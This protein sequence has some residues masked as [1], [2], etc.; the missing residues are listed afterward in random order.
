MKTA[1]LNTHATAATSRN[2]NTTATPTTATNCP[3][4]KGTSGASG[5]KHSPFRGLG[6]FF[7]T[8]LLL[9]FATTNAWAQ[10]LTD[11]MFAKGFGGYTTNGF[12]AAG[13]DRSGKA[14]ST[15]KTDVE[16]S[17]QVFNGSTGAVR[18]NQSTLKNNFSCRNT[19]TKEGYYI[20]QVSL[21]VS[22]G[23]ID[24]S[25]SGR[26]VVYFGETAFT[27]SPSGTP[28]NASPAS[29]GQTTL[30]WTN[31]DTD[32]SYFILFGL[33][34]SGTA[35]SANE[36]TSLKVVWSPAG[37]SGTEN[38]LAF[39]NG[40]CTV[41]NMIELST[42]KKTGDNNVTP[43]TYAFEG[44]V[45]NSDAE[46]S[47]GIFYGYKLGTYTINATQAEGNGYCAGTAQFTVTVNAPEYTYTWM[48]NGMQHD[49]T[50]GSTVVLPSTNP[51]VPIGCEG[52]MFVGWT[53]EFS[54]SNA[55]TAPTFVKAGDN[56]GS[57]KTFYAVFA[58]E[59][60]EGGSGTAQYEKVTSDQ[61][62]WEGQYLIAYS[63]A[64][65][66]DGSLSGT[67]PGALNKKVAPESNLTGNN[68]TATWGDTY[69]FTLEAVTGGYVL[70]SKAG[71]YLYQTTNA[72]G[73]KATDNQSTAASYP[74]TV[75][76]TSASDIKLK[77]GGA[78][79]G[80]VL[81]Y[82]TSGYFRYYKNGGQSAIYLY[83]KSGGS[84][85]TYSD[86]TTQCTQPCTSN[87]L[88]FRN[89][90]CFV[91][92]EF[93]LSSL[94]SGNST[95]DIIY[96][97]DDEDNVI[98]VDNI[99]SAITAGVY[100]VTAYQ[101]E[102]N[103]ICE[104]SEI[105]FTVTVKPVAD[106][107][108][109]WTFDWQ[110]TPG[111]TEWSRL[112]FDGPYSP[113]A[114]TGEYTIAN[115]T[116]P[117]G[118]CQFTVGYEGVYDKAHWGGWCYKVNFNSHMP[119]ANYRGWEIKPI[120]G[121][122]AVGTL[123]I[124][125]NS[126]SDNK[127]IGFIPSGYSVT[128]GIEGQGNEAT[129]VNVPFSKKEGEN[130]IWETAEVIISSSFS[131][132]TKY[133]TGITKADPNALSAFCNNKSNTTLM[134]PLSTQIG[135]GVHGIF[136]MHDTY[137]NADGDNF[138][139]TFM[140]YYNIV[141][142]KSDNT[143]IDHVS[144][145]KSC[146]L[147]RDNGE[148]DVT[149]DAPTEVREGYTFKGWSHEQ[150]GEV[151][152]GV[153]GTYTLDHPNDPLY[154]VWSKNEYTITW[155]NNGTTFATTTVDW[156]K[157]ITTLPD[158]PESCDATYSNFV[159]W[160][161]EA[162]GTQSA[163]NTSAP[164]TQV[165]TNT[166]PESNVTYHAVF[167][168]AEGSGAE[169]WSLTELSNITASD[170][171]VIAWKNES[172]TY[173]VMSNDKGTSSAPSAT[174]V[175]V[176]SN[177]ITSTIAATQKWN[178]SNSSG[179]LTIYPQGTT[180]TWLYC[181]STNNG[182]RVGN[183][184]N[185]IF[186]IDGESGYLKNT[187]TSRY[188]GVYNNAD[189]RC[190]I[191]STATNIQNQTLAFFKKSIDG[192][193]ATGY[194]SSCC[195]DPA[196]VT[197]TPASASVNL[198]ENGDASVNVTVS[199]EGVTVDNS[200]LSYSVS[201]ETEGVSFNGSTFS[202]TGGVAKVGT[203]TIS[204]AYTDNC[205][206]VGSATIEVKATPVVT[207]V[208]ADPISL[209]AECGEKET[210][211]ITVS[212]YN[213]GS[214]KVKLAFEPTTMFVTI[215]E[216][217][218]SLTPDADGKV[219]KEITITYTASTNTANAGTVEYSG[220]LKASCG[221][222]EPASVTITATKSSTCNTTRVQ[223]MYKDAELGASYDGYYGEAIDATAV[224]T[225]GEQAQAAVC[226]TPT[227]Y[228]FVGWS[229]T[230]NEVTPVTPTDKTVSG[231]SKYYAY[232][233]YVENGET[234]TTAKPVCGAYVQITNN[235][236]VYVTGGIGT[237]YNTVQ[238]QAT[239]DFVAD[240]LV[241]KTGATEDP[242]VRVLP[243]DITV[244]GTQTTEIKVEQLEQTV[245][246][247]TDGTFKSVGKFIVKYTPTTAEQSVD[248]N[249][250][251]SVRNV[252]LAS[253][254]AFTVHARSLPEQFVIVGQNNGTWYA[255]P[256]NMD[257]AAT[258]A[259]NTQLVLDNNNP[260]VAEIAPNAAVYKFDAMPSTEFR[261][262]RF[263]GNDNSQYLWATQASDGEGTNIRNWATNTPAYSETYYNWLLTTTDN[264]TYT[265]HNQGNNRN[266]SL[267]GEKFGMF[268]SG[269]DQLRIL[270]ITE[271]CNYAPAPA[272]LAVTNLGETTATAT[273][274][275]ISGVSRYEYK[276]NDGGWTTV[277]TNSATLGLVKGNAYTLTVRAKLDGSNTCVD[278]A[279]TT[280]AAKNYDLTIGNCP[281]II[282][283][284]GETKQATVT[285][286]VVDVTTL[287]AGTITGDH[288]NMF[289]V[290]AGVSG[291]TVT[292]APPAGTPEG[293]YTATVV[294]TGTPG[295]RTQTLTLR[296]RVQNTIAMQI[297]CDWDDFCMDDGVTD[298][299]MTPYT[300]NDDT[301][302]WSN[303]NFKKG[304]DYWSDATGMVR[305]TDMTTGEDL[306][307][308][309]IT[310]TAYNIR[311]PKSAL[312]L[313]HSYRFEIDNSDGS[314][315]NA[316][317]TPYA[318]AVYE[319]TA[320]YCYSVTA[321]TPCAISE[322]GFT[323]RWDCGLDNTPA[324][325]TLEVYTKVPGAT[326]WSIDY[327]A[328]PTL[329]IWTYAG[330][331][332]MQEEGG[333][334]SNLSNSAQISYTTDG[335]QI[336]KAS[337]FGELYSPTFANMQNLPTDLAN[338]EVT[339]SITHV[340]NNKNNYSFR[341]YAVE[342]TSAKAD[343]PYAK[344][345]MYDVYFNGS[346]TKTSYLTISGTPTDQ[347]TTFTVKGLTST[348]HILIYGDESTAAGP[349]IK[350]VTI[351]TAT[352]KSVLTTGYNSSVACANGDAG[353]A[354]TGL[355][356][357][358]TYYY[359][360]DGTNEIAV[361]TRSAAPE[362]NFELSK[363]TLQS[364][365]ACVLGKM[366]VSGTNLTACQGDFSWVLTGEDKSKFSG[367][368]TNL[369]Y[370]AT[371][372][373]LSGYVVVEY[374]PTESGTDNATLT[375]TVGDVS[376]DIVLEGLSCLDMAE[377]TVT[378]GAIYATL[379]LQEETSG[380]VAVT[381]MG[382]KN[383]LITNPGFES[384]KSGWGTYIT[385]YQ[386]DSERSTAQ[387]HSG[388]AS[389]YASHG[390]D[391]Y[392]Q[393]NG[394]RYHLLAPDFRMTAGNTY[395]F[396]AWVYPTD[397]EDFAIGYYDDEASTNVRDYKLV[398]LKKNTWT[399]VSIT[400][401]V[402]AAASNS[403]L[404]PFIARRNHSSWNGFYVDDVVLAQTGGSATES[405]IVNN[406]TTVTLDDLTPGH[407]YQYYLTNTNTGCKYGP[408]EFATNDSVVQGAIIIDTPIELSVQ[409]SQSVSKMVVVD[410]KWLA[411]DV[412]IMK[413]N[414]QLGGGVNDPCSWFTIN[415]TTVDANG[416]MISVTFSPDI[417]AVPGTSFSCHCLAT[418]VDLQGTQVTT[419]FDLIGTVTAGIDPSLPLVEVVDIDETTLVIEHNVADVD[420]VQIVLNRELT[421][422]EIQENVGCELFFSKYYEASSTVKLWAVFNP[423]NDTISLKGTYVWLG[424]NGN[425]WNKRCDLS[426]M[427][428][429]K[430]GYIAPQEE[431]IVY[432]SDGR[433]AILNC[434]S[435][436]ADMTNWYG[437]KPAN[438]NALSFDGNDAL[439][440]VRSPE[441]NTDEKV[442]T[443][444]YSS[445][446]VP[447]MYIL[448]EGK[449]T[450]RDTILNWRWYDNYDQDPGVMYQILD[451]VG[452]RTAANV[453]DN[454]KC[455]TPKFEDGQ[456]GD[457]DGWVSTTGADMN[458]KREIVL[459]TN[460]CLLVRDKGVKAGSAAV[461]DNVGDFIT[462][463]SEWQGS[464]VPS[465]SNR[466]NEDSISC[467]NFTYVGAFDYAGYYATYTTLNADEY[468]FTLQ[469]RDS[470]YIAEN[471]ESLTEYTCKKLLIE[472]VAV[473]N[474]NGTE[475]KSLVTS[476]EYKVPII[477][478]SDIKTTDDKFTQFTVDTC[479]ECDVVIIDN[480]KLTREVNSD[481]K[482][483]RAQF[484]NMSVF[485][486][487]SLY[488]PAN[489]ELT[490]NHLEMRATNDTVSY[491]IVDGTLN[492][493]GDLVHQKRIDD[494]NWYS[495][496]L[497]Y[498]CKLA[499]IRQFNGKS[500]GTYDQDWWIQYYD[501]AAR[502]EDGTWDEN[503]GYN[504]AT[505]WKVCDP[506]ATLQPNQ[507]YLIGIGGINT[508][509]R[510]K[511]VY[512]PPLNQGE[513]YTESGA[514]AVSLAVKAY[515]GA[516]T[517]IAGHENDKGW[518]FIGHPYIT[519]FNHENVAAGHGT[520]NDVVKMGSW[521]GA[522]Y[523]E[524]DKVYVNIPKSGV[525]DYTQDLAAFLQ[526]SPFQGHFVQV[527]GDADATLTFHKDGRD[528]EKAAAPM[529]AAAQEVHAEVSLAL[530]DANGNLD[531]TG[532]LVDEAYSD[533]YEVARDLTK[534]SKKTPTDKPYLSSYITDGTAQELVFNALPSNSAHCIPL[535][536]YAPTAGDY[537][538]TIDR[539]RS[540][541]SGVTAVLL[542]AEGD[543]I[544]DL[545]A[546]DY[547]LTTKHA[548][549]TFN[550]VYS[551]TVERKAQVTTDVTFNGFDVI[552][553]VLYTEG[554]HLRV[555]QLPQSGELHLV[556]AVGR[557][558]ETRKLD[559]TSACDLQ[560]Q[561]AG[562][563]MVIVRNAEQTFT[564]RTIAQ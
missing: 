255:L 314:V 422:E 80:A 318:S 361:T 72:N 265:I 179:N 489:T 392:T 466:D 296:G 382:S 538:F 300:D 113:D 503:G 337:T 511:S 28:T 324:T 4:C 521:D 358:T 457:E 420:E 434:A 327:T 195:S 513:T 61:E 60:D 275:A 343:V 405:Y 192:K 107:T 263:L 552:S 133:Y 35:L 467:E 396:S 40:T 143:T 456:S 148:R 213:C 541:L 58:T 161:T 44:T 448:D 556:D 245:T 441:N 492:V 227:T 330:L 449:E 43:I 75:T 115:F 82:N 45:S 136:R 279:S 31:T 310:N 292:F 416:G 415:P 536:V 84:S 34:T 246:Q 483:D 400:F 170:E 407:N 141:Y 369:V 465:D 8:L 394:V 52:A 487:G 81:C 68:I 321:L 445:P 460:R 389:L 328:K 354:V 322:N 472:C 131:A 219:S 123:H 436:K 336:S 485:T 178:I 350:D 542:H 374:C 239:I 453:V 380:V 151:A 160:F 210:A 555:E 367:D 220:A 496:S 338:A 471:F 106:I 309:V 253:A 564:L 312:T 432:A 385:G 77:L 48:S 99:F 36:T 359:T 376:D 69:C 182:V 525:S 228:T 365:G 12:S 548:K 527:A 117:A 118:N 561:A 130:D 454:S 73:I 165:T 111:A 550:K 249:V 1:L 181:I 109:K 443:R 157:P 539:S 287:E 378:P 95:A 283:Q 147:N 221:T 211:K 413:G 153:G 551:I 46:I 71:S 317:G 429:H 291:I 363:L 516:S 233:S 280:F 126:N 224:T 430:Q 402:Q 128:Y 498:E 6:G 504:G 290:T 41:E 214:E 563:Y 530:V 319:A 282:A 140:P 114:G 281:V 191:T 476:S 349:R 175:T 346:D 62:N 240:A 270:P 481:S 299:Y 438:E 450:E 412:T 87:T 284:P 515:T 377:P 218:Q 91:D 269:K 486:G 29:S 163:P 528:W 89:G 169:V 267:Y 121:E 51:A 304:D 112:V 462:L 164:A 158:A 482:K 507:A 59:I 146:E 64:I 93:N 461:M 437:M 145:Y 183:S 2:L 97:C 260:T 518:N 241:K 168:D 10:D 271:I 352:T 494:K 334:H 517:A 514:D 139:T 274:D 373:T 559:G 303:G 294:I 50:S 512:F 212:A 215:A 177:K 491:A 474:V 399:Q 194:I 379:T 452:A 381:D 523:I 189:V 27:T 285:V 116:I 403:S 383:N 278:E 446:D 150:N 15:N 289:S 544:A 535:C 53:T 138:Q 129:W 425:P 261:Y 311:I 520:N 262:V 234:K 342:T 469:E 298:F 21:T 560:V 364:G 306:T 110:A 340:S 206:K 101:E 423:T 325:K 433:G 56:V 386:V 83:K 276:L 540:D 335:I 11:I 198:D 127:D 55:T 174:S 23:T 273:W 125:G 257:A 505:Y 508:G 348:S 371:T 360:V 42:L 242:L 529:R 203:Y 558:I 288:K 204:A 22:G 103:G 207:L 162:A 9:L 406:T 193:P 74:I 428:R 272:N 533:S 478:S 243:A 63:D 409:A 173:Y 362:L 351:K 554:L 398:S 347:T 222:G 477:V 149:I 100:S 208:Q 49:K 497:P 316:D 187:A 256:A 495:F 79:A 532:I 526:M 333:W 171:V 67:D 401:T 119:L 442:E 223:F 86:Y 5:V 490:V 47:D 372:G 384:D 463:G 326:M 66:M 459:S 417:N 185:K 248:V 308:K 202:V 357:G 447:F 252:D 313:G 439:A 375:L 200:K 451:L 196:V 501:G 344:N 534:M 199:V 537:T 277:A 24:G 32:V 251:L 180:A 65:F 519:V 231:S 562:V 225:A 510:L 78:A 488:I 90:E 464:H 244:N 366:Y 479:K 205:A 247:N 531:R 397:D 258:Y 232:F 387:K 557:V 132:D 235:R 305:L 33:K 70:K 238:A 266:L 217:N 426:T 105:T 286:T 368:G 19:T 16:Y 355:T 13:T 440:L 102:G 172:G 108:G 25:T 390:A 30:T 122:G 57:D 421:E 98:I 302:N 499:S 500:L 254:D 502:A 418:S 419:A 408:W 410:T 54:Y 435:G 475:V 18:G 144:A 229:S 26:S 39:N 414:E 353:A 268:A 473:N 323:A 545:L 331:T 159:G 543:V 3:L 186:T 320:H 142:Y 264:E 547:T 468:A 345:K 427:G 388:S 184:D 176:S 37:C 424:S 209:T 135:A 411:Q 356:K 484:R 124:Y 226:T 92:G 120:P 155:V 188:L 17:M 404:Y 259:G 197:V 339:I 553:P 190:Y 152:I 546:G 295:N 341:V 455:T 134:K 20:S 156:T 76:F 96:V 85:T 393:I 230:L 522:K 509:N 370:D 38:N 391:G 236:E 237:H 493:T 315:V 94:K 297:A 444:R 301:H 307:S 458:G 470:T 332:S 201:P 167:S 104:S 549:Q 88:A 216:A 166:V 524:T 137:G 14:N 250:K 7:F 329:N 154:P 431:L 293:D 480:A 395:A 506:Y